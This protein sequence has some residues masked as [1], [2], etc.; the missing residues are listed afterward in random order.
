MQEV[1]QPQ[2]LPT[3]SSGEMAGCK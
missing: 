1:S 2:L 3:A